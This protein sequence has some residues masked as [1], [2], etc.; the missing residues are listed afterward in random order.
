M[1][2]HVSYIYIV[3]DHVKELWFYGHFHLTIEFYS[4]TNLF[5]LKKRQII[6]V[7]YRM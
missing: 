6:R 3:T 5:V 1:T 7:K 2:W 4:I